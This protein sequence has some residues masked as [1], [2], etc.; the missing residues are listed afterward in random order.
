VC[1]CVCLSVQKWLNNNRDPF[2]WVTQVGPSNRALDAARTPTNS[3]PLL[4]LAHRT[5]IK[6]S[7]QSSLDSYP[8]RTNERSQLIGWEERL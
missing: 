3:P 4:G 7:V 1:L 2:W 6:V 5:N 8:Q